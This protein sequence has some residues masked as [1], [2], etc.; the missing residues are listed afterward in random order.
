[1]TAH[2]TTRFA[3][4][5]TSPIVTADDVAASTASFP[6]AARVLPEFRLSSSP[7]PRSDGET[8]MSVKGKVNVFSRVRPGLAREDGDQ[9]CIINHPELKKCVVRVEDYAV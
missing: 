9:H 2:I 5:A 8:T 1:M 7:S 4:V 3:R 6:H